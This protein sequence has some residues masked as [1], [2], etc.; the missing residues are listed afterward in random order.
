MMI[1]NL[2]K[3]TLVI[4]LFVTGAC[5][6][7]SPASITA[8]VDVYVSGYSVATDSSTIIRYWKNGKPTIC[9]G[10]IWGGF[11]NS[12]A[13]AGSDVYLG[14]ILIGNNGTVATTWKNGN[15]LSLDTSHQSYVYK[16]RVSGNDV[17]QCGFT[18]KYAALSLA[19]YWKNGKPVAVT[20]GKMSGSVNDMVINGT[21]LYLLVEQSD[22][23]N[24]AEGIWKN[25]KLTNFFTGSLSDHSTWS[26]FQSMTVSSGDVYVA[27]SIFANNLIQAGYFKNGVLV[28]VADGIHHSHA[29]DIC[30]SGSDIYVSGSQTTGSVNTMGH[31]DIAMC[32]KNGIAQNLT[33]GKHTAQATGITVSGTDVYVSGYEDNGT[34][35]VA[36]YWKNGQPVILSTGKRNSYATSIAV[37]AH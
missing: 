7:S 17:Y 10:I 19:T 2:S 6:K 24:L 11:P 18:E 29:Y 33:D 20:D 9:N 37:I 21:D 4:C 14:G 23:N 5:K 1:Q 26:D 28:N 16:V 12:I 15:S 8:N 30:V 13:V 35:M 32:W 25:G 31:I 36:K 34:N 3:I 22:V 27:T